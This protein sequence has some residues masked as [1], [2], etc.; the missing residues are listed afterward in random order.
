MSSWLSSAWSWLKDEWNAFEA[1]VNT[2]MPG[3]K[4]L[5]VSALG[6]VSSGAAVM[7]QYISGL[8]LDKF[9]NATQIAVL[10]AVLFTLAFWFHGLGSRVD[11]RAADVTT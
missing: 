7:Q 2:W 11:A 9:M 8:P 6:A 1:W 5:I 3:L 10:T 4:T